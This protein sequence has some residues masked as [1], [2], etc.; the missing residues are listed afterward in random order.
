MEDVYLAWINLGEGLEDLYS[1]TKA[2]D[3]NDVSLR[4]LETNSISN[5]D[6]GYSSPPT[7]VLHSR[8]GV[9]DLTAKGVSQCDSIL[10]SSFA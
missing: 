9:S 6:L 8:C 5:L 2:S 3:N 1:S 7:L 4:T 10:P